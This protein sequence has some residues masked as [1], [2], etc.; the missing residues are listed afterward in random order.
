M[1]LLVL[2]LYVGPLFGQSQI[3]TVAEKSTLAPVEGV[4]FTSALP[5][6]NSI[7]NVKGQVDLEPFKGAEVIVVQHVSYRTLSF[8]YDQLVAL[9]GEL[10][11][12]RQA[13]TLEEFVTSASRFDEKRRDVPEKIDVIQAREIRQYETQTTADLL[14]NSGTVFVQKSQLGGGSPV[15]RG[16]EAS[17]ILLVVDGVRMNTAIYRAGHLQDIVTMD[18]NALEKVEV[19]SGPASVAYGSDALGGVI[20][21]TTRTPKL[22]GTTDDRFLGD[23]FMRYSSAN[24]EKTAHAGFEL[25]G[26]K[27]SSFTSITASNFG[28]LRQ[29]STR[30]PFY[31]DFGR[32]DW[33]VERINGMDS[34]VVNDDSN[35]Q[36]GSGYEQLDLLQKFR[37][38]GGIGVTHD[39]NVQYSTSTDVPRYDRLTQVRN[40]APRYAEWYYGPQK[41][42][43]ASYAL[44]IEKSHGLFDRMR[45]I[46]S[47]QALEQSRNSRNYRKDDLTSQVENVNVF[48]LNADLEKRA[49]KHEIRYGLEGTYNDVSSAAT[50]TNT[51]TGEVVPAQTRYADGGASMNTAAAYISHTMELSPKWVISEGLRY[52]RTG[53]EATFKDTANYAF[54]V[55]RTTQINSAL[56]GRLGVMY[57]PGKDW[58]FSVLGSTGFRSPNVDDLSKVFDSA[59]GLVIVPNTSLK[60]ERTMNL[61]ATISKTISDMVTLEGTGFVTWFRDA[62]TVGSAQFNGQDSIVYDG[63]T[64]KVTT[65]QNAGKAYLYGGSGSMIIQFDRGFVLRSSVNFTYGRIETDTTD[66]PLDHVPPVY[67]RTSLEW[68]VK[69]FRVESYVLYNGWKRLMDYNASGEDNLSYATA[70]GM[71]A[72]YTLNL[73]AAFTVSKNIMLQAGLENI[74]DTNYRTFSSNISAPGRNFTVS[75]RANF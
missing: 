71:P 67:G 13:Y 25:R 65:M 12:D 56:S 36:V 73:R 49:G 62:L 47:F 24:N 7:S 39:L 64:S 61:E 18:Q 51:V 54:L 26:K 35:V 33:S 14:Q 68:N 10:L 37:L 57:M 31:E 55:G 34:T 72:W 66:V 4:S 40:G 52:T 69:R 9:G 46:P 48:A 75:L 1:T 8:S 3:I 15:I 23:A 6:V 53:L 21:F 30:N 50:K 45:I 22:L 38:A 27:L 58:R 32:R 59:P 44:N 17:K 60:P 41:R 74:M 63:V 2:M 16:F 29:G 28:D 43:L 5:A 42:F 20:H 19:I 70:N 11:L